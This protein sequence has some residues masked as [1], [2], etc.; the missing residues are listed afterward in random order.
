M[1]GRWTRRG[2]RGVFDVTTRLYLLEG[3]IDD[4]EAAMRVMDERLA[5]HTKLLTGILIAVTTASI[6]LA[7]NVLVATSTQ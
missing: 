1:S 7:I 4:M 6:M 5:T 3:D 2:A